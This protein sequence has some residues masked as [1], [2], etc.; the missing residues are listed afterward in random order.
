MAFHTFSCTQTSE[1]RKRKRD[2][3]LIQSIYVL[4]YHFPL[5]YVALLMYRMPYLNNVTVRLLK[6]ALALALMCVCKDKKNIFPKSSRFQ[7]I[8]FQVTGMLAKGI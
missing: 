6:K 5:I 2:C 1:I 7:T 8:N 3:P 4:L